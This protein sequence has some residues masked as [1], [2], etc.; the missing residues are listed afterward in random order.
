MKFSAATIALTA[1]LGVSAIPSGHGHG[2]HALR[3]VERRGNFV[4]AHRP[5][6]PEPVPEPPKAPETK[7]PEPTTTAVQEAPKPTKSTAPSSG[8]GSNSGG[9]AKPFCNGN[10]KR[11]IARATDA[12]IHYT[13]NVGVKGAYGCNLMVVDND[14]ADKYKY[15]T[16]F[17][18]AAGTDQKCVCFLKI[19][20]DGGVNGFFKGNQALDFDLPAGSEKYVAADEN[21]QGG[22]ACGAGEVPLTDKGQFASTWLEFDFGSKANDGWSG[23][24][25]S[26]LLSAAYGLDIPGLNVCGHGNCSTIY[27]GGEGKNAFLAG[28]EALDG[29]GLN[30]PAG[31]ARLEVTV[32]YSGN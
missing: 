16:K 25:A 17:T 6:L 20:A 30:L 21:T 23:A 3:S 26:C 13:G 7:A 29:L 8:S 2:H 32:G 9:Y 14:K 12:D 28:M 24:D 19:G 15:T 11:I 18:N 4:I 5:K 10:T 31:E 27:P 22:C 1:A